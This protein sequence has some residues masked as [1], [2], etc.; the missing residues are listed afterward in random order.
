MLRTLRAGGRSQRSYVRFKRNKRFQMIGF[1]K[2]LPPPRLFLSTE[3]MGDK[4]NR[5]S[6]N[7]GKNIKIINQSVNPEKELCPS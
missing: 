7:F 4:E 5:V 3:P 2:H 6:Y 1:I